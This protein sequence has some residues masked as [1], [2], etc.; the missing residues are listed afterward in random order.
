MPERL[1]KYVENVDEIKSFI[2]DLISALTSGSTTQLKNSST[3]WLKM[4]GPI[5]QQ[6]LKDTLMDARYEIY[7][8]GRPCN[9]KPGD[10]T[11]AQLEP[12]NPYREKVMRVEQRFYAAYFLTSPYGA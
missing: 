7:L 6:Q 2:K 3:G 4:T 12:T 1:F 8:R 5:T 11:C 9:G 10:A